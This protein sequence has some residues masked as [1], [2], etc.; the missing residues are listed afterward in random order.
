MHRRSQSATINTRL[1]PTRDAAYTS[2]AFNCGSGAI[3]KSTATRRLNASDIAGDCEALTWWNS[4]G[5][6]SAGFSSAACA[7]RRFA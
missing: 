1:P 7:K 5:G 6:S 4:G 3:G 2:T